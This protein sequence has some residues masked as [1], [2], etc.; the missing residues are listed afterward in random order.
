MCTELKRLHDIVAGHGIDDDESCGRVTKAL[1][2]ALLNAYGSCYGYKNTGA[3]VNN[4]YN[5]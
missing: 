2:F 3:S 5:I 4:A 1:K